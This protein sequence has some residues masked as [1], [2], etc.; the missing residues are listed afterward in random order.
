M[1]DS[2]NPLYRY[3]M[4]QSR[5]QFFS[6]VGKG[7]GVAAL[8]SLLGDDGY[9]S[10]GSAESQ[11]VPFGPHFAPKAKRVIYLFQSGGPS[12]IDLF[13][14]KP[15]MDKVRGQDLPDSIRRG[16]RLT[17][18]TS[19]QDR[20]PV[21]NSIFEFSRHGQSG[22][23]VSELMPHTASIVDEICF[24]KSMHTEQIN[25]DP[26]IT[27]FQTGFQLAGRPSIG[28]W[29]SYGLGSMNRDLPAFIALT[30]AVRAGLPV[31]LYTI[32]YGFRVYAD[33]LCW[34]E[35]SLSSRPSAFLAGSSRD[36]SF[37]ATAD[38][39]RA[40]GTE[41]S[42]FGQNGRCRN[43]EP[44]LPSMNWLIECRVACRN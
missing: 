42:T 30:S 28:S 3:S 4:T 24:I 8:S 12:Q 10:D 33:F 5:R 32:V 9:A 14:H 2:V 37:H 7:I 17:G 39:G 21:A 44:A 27:F 31:S 35:T 29:M 41:R 26:A 16:Q 11:G 25:H 22:A 18:M 1:N 23:T 34:R 19:G 13:D 43:S 6:T 15:Y 38:A 36:L 20:F 40:C